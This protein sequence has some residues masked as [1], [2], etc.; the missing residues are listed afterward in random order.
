MPQFFIKGEGPADSSQYS[1]HQAN[2]MTVYIKN[3][4][5]LED[6]VRVRF[7]KVAS[8]LSGREFEAVGVVPPVQ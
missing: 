3:E 6:E 7:P 5:T 4:L 8:D 2:D 1:K